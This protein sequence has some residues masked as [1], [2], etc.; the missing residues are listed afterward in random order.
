M[1][2]PSYSSIVIF[3]PIKFPIIVSIVR[4]IEQIVVL[5]YSQRLFIIICMR[6]IVIKI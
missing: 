3:D 1:A 4:V 6:T 5:I 2:Y